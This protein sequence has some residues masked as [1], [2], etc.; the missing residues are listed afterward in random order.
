VGKLVRT[1]H[2]HMIDLVL[3]IRL[4]SPTFGKVI[5]HDMPAR[6]EDDFYQWIWLPPGFAHGNLFP[7]D[8]LIEYFCTGEYNPACEAGISPLAADIDWSLCERPLK[9]AFDAI[10]RGTQ[11]I[12]D[13]DKVGLSVSTWEQDERSRHFVYGG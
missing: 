11:L 1:V 7:E 12:S 13:K 4:G 5:A 8:T 9:A 10:A 6:R 3:D 2:G